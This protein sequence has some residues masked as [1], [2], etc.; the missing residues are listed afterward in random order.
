MRILVV[1]DSEYDRLVLLHTIEK[2]APKAQVITAATKKEALAA[3]DKLRFDLVFMDVM[4]PDDEIGGIRATEAIVKNDAH[5][6]V[7]LLTA[8]K[9]N[10]PRIQEAIETDG[11]FH[12]QKPVPIEDIA[13]AIDAVRKS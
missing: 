7:V 8:L 11:V 12:F 10:D 5:T 3:I 13:M 2:A 9:D 1:E 4:L 6:V